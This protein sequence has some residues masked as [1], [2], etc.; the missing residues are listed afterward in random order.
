MAVIAY[1]DAMTILVSVPNDIFDALKQ[2]F[3]DKEIVEITG[4]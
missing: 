3:T 2:H 1:S 4:S